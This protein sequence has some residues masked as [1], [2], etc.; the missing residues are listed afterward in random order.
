MQPHGNPI[1]ARCRSHERSGRRSNKEIS[2]TVHASRTGEDGAVVAD[3]GVDERLALAA[4]RAV[5]QRMRQQQRR[6]HSRQRIAAVARA[7]ARVE[8]VMVQQLQQRVQRLRAR[9][10]R[11]QARAE[12]VSHPHEQ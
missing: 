5:G 4:R 3:E 12:H 6:K 11:L 8:A 10:V 2:W 9:P 1:T 7:R